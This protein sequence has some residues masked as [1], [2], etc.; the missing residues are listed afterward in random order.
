M[1]MISGIVSL[2]LLAFALIGVAGYLTVLSLKPSKDEKL[3][4]VVMPESAEECEF[5]VRAAAERM[6]WLEKN[7]SCRLI[8]LNREEDPDIDLICE[9]LSEQY[10][11]LQ[12][13]NCADLGYTIKGSE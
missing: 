13:S 1:T 11:Y 4:V 3:S 6:K 12:V 9:L 8:C 10:P 7:R 2:C 5:V